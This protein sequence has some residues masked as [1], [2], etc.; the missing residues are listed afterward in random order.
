M[1]G[2]GG[3]PLNVF[4]TPEQVPFYGGTYFPPEPR[5]RHAR[6]DAG[7]AGDRRAVE[8]APRGDPGGRRAPARAAARAPPARALRRSRST[9]ARAGERRGGARRQPSTRATAASAARRSSRSA[10]ALE[11][12]LLRGERAMSLA[13]PAR[14]GARRH[15][16]PARRRLRP[17][18]RRRDLDRAPLREDALRQRAARARL[19]ARLAGVRRRAAARRVPRHARAGRCARCAAPE[20]GFYSALD[21]D[22]EGVEGRFYVWTLDELR[23]LLGDDADAAIAWFGAS[24][25]GNFVDPHHPEP[26]LNVLTGPRPAPAAGL[27]ERIRERLLAARAQRARP[28]L[29][30]KRLTSWNALMIAALADAGAVL[31]EPRYREAAIAC[32]EFICGSSMRDGRAAA[33]HLQRRRRP[34]IDRLPRGPRV[35]AR[36]AARAVR[37]DAA[38]SAGSAR[39]VE[40]ADELIERFADTERRRLLLDRRRRRTADR[41]AQGPRGLRRSPPAPR[42]PRSA[43][44]DS[45]SSPAS[46]LRAPR[47]CRCCASRGASPP[48]TRA[49]SATC[50]RRCT[51]TSRPP[52]RS[53]ARCPPASARAPAQGLT[54][55]TGSGRAPS[56]V[57]CTR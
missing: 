14:D 48:A 29:D 39:R 9:R 33:A 20:G 32:A 16:R 15:P 53:P 26:G 43:C 25:Q 51:G 21:A 10:S 50:C 35:P 42:A 46:R 11:F 28:A 52:G 19:P 55:S 34:R 30:D 8:R 6:L 23:E 44:C 38:R 49:P 17:L 7:A 24:E 57:T 4:L 5:Q 47:G 1:T 41:A 36:G 3:W 22:S 54:G 13:T 18:Q 45:R 27:R 2:H 56:C 40:L 31:G 12:L 37:S